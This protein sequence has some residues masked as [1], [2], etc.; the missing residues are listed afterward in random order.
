[1]RGQSNH[2]RL[3]VVEEPEV[4]YAELAGDYVAFS[5]FGDGPI[6]LAVAQGR[7]PID[8]MWQLP[9]LATFMGALG[10]LARVIIWDARGVGASDPLRDATAALSERFADDMAAV[11]DAAGSD[12][13]TIFEMGAAT[14]IAFAATYPDRVRSLILVNFRLSYPEVRA[15]SAA[16]L[17]Q[18]AM[19]LRSPERLRF[20]NPR[21]AH[22]PVLQRWWGHAMRLANSP[23]GYEI[24]CRH[25]TPMSEPCC[26]S[27]RR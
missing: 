6:D 21:A 26:T 4:R 24:S 1:V 20:E 12:R 17:K 5:V 23:E 18:L 16:Q 14:S 9:Q 22:D 8:L 15:I 19:T 25:R 13:V 11:L 7:F 2:V 10:R 3:V 27:Y